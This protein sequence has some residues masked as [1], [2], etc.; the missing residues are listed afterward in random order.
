M[1]MGITYEYYTMNTESGLG[2]LSMLSAHAMHS[3]PIHN[4]AQAR[5]HSV[6]LSTFMI[7]LLRWKQEDQEC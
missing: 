7:K 6:V 1:V 5:L 2:M 4:C 3:D